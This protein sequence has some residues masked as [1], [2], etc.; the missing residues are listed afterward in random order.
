MVSVKKKKKYELHTPKSGWNKNRVIGSEA[1]APPLQKIK[2]AWIY[3][4]R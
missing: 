4:I 1:R 3:L 2:V